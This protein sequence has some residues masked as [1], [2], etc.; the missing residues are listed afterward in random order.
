MSIIR[1]VLNNGFFILLLI[2][3]AI[4]YIAYSDAIKK[5]HGLMESEPSSSIPLTKLKQEDGNEALLSNNDVVDELN[6]ENNEPEAIEILAKAEEVV[7]EDKTAQ[8]T[9]DVVELSVEN[10]EPETIEILAKA[11]LA[12]VEDKT[13]ADEKPPQTVAIPVEAT[14][15]LETAKVELSEEIDVVDSVKKPQEPKSVKRSEPIDVEKVLSNYPSFVAALS[16]ARKFATAKEYSQSEEIYY[17]LTDKMPNATVLG[18]FGDVLHQSGKDDLAEL[19]WIEAGRALIKN[20]RLNEATVFAKRL[21]A[22]S[23]KASKAILVEAELAQ[24][25]RKEL[26]AKQQEQ[27]QQQVAQYNAKV[28]Q[29]QDAVKFAREA[30]L[31]KMA[32]YHADKKAWWDAENKKR[33]SYNQVKQQQLEV[34]RKKMQDYYQKLNAY[35]KTMQSRNNR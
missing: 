22:I 27:R 35:Y 14:V 21:A 16:A 29:R 25:K 20:N 12:V 13:V 24:E 33:Q 15:V 10:N 5:D 2:V 11:E 19:S 30:Y 9:S 32:K 8:S 4:I 1:T 7:V 31:K 34:Y 3:I 6:T 18:E 26:A 17:S 23:E 28:K